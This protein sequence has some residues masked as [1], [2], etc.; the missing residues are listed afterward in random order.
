MGSGFAK[1]KKEARLLHQKM[2][3]MQSAMK[4]KR[5]VGR[6][7]NGLVTVTLNGEHD[8]LAIE[9]KRECVDPEEVEGL[10]DLIMAAH[11]DAT[12]QLEAESPA[13]P[14]F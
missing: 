13:F 9:L 14:G 6:A 10:Q 8:L 12:Q 4:E 5:V 1:K 2:H 11:R 3:E 7:G